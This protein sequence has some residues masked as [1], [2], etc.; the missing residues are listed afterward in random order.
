[1]SYGVLTICMENPAKP[2]N[3][4]ENS[5]GTVQTGENCP[6]KSNTFRGITFYPFFF[7]RNDRIFLYHLFGLP[8]PGF[9]SRESEKFTGI[10]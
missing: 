10:L 7:S 9:R 8:V 1:M 6:E 4:G 2:G 3:S 5:T